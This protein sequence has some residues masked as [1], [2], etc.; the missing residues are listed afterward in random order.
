MNIIKACIKNKGKKILTWGLILVVG[1]AAFAAGTHTAKAEETVIKIEYDV[2]SNFIKES[3][4]ELYGYG[5]EYI[6]LLLNQY[7]L[8][9]G[10][11]LYQHWEWI[12]CIAAALVIVLLVYVVMTRRATDLKVKQKENELLEKKLQLDELT[13]LYNRKYFFEKARELID[14]SKEEM[15]IIRI[16]VL[17]FKV[18]N[19]IYGMVVGD[20][21]LAEIGEQVAKMCDKP[22]SIAARFMSDYYFMCMP[23]A[24]FEKMRVPSRIKT[25]LEDIEIKV[26][27]GVFLVEGQKD[28]EVNLMCD[29]ANT[30]A[31]NKDFTYTKHIYFYNDEQRQQLMVTQEI[32]HEMEQAIEERQFETYIQPKYDVKTRE[33]VGGEALV[34]WKH[35][36]K[37]MI[38][39]GV[40]ID[41][42]ERNGF[43]VW[44]DYYVWEETCRMLA[45]NKKAGLKSVPVSINVSKA[46]FYGNSLRKKLNRL[47]KRNGLET[48]DLELEITESICAEDPTVVFEILRELQQD[49]FRIAMDDFGSGY[50]S[51]N[52]L[53]EMP[54]DII[55][56]DLKFLSGGENEL[57]SYYILK[58]LIDLAHAL[59]LLVVVEGV[60]T[61][62]QVEF[63]QQFYGCCAQG[64]YFSRPVES[65]VYKEM[66]MNEKL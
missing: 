24:E 29:R 10:N 30:A 1:L 61:E 34:R 38:S 8:G 5:V 39:P 65:R 18:V 53:K 42:F 15:C 54:L 63:L 32:E 55:K 36:V 48:S 46:H 12:L 9:A 51:L 64:Y 49:G 41:V 3:N 35:P 28:L 13:G 60:E 17:N 4:G 14:S 57:K 25:S 2:N 33:I 20:R 37:G 23:R 62:S 59:D 40:F 50:S 66:L 47:I 22:L 26:V 16:N 27:Y 7:V 56:M 31:Q 6:K 52:M 11:L 19:E 45:E 43:I 44:L 21:I 58:S